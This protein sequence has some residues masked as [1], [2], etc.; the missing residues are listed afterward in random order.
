M[1][2]DPIEIFKSYP[3]PPLVV[4]DE[5]V[6]NAKFTLPG[7]GLKIRLCKI[8]YDGQEPPQA[9]SGWVKYWNEGG[10]DHLIDSMV[11]WNQHQGDTHTTLCPRPGWIP[12]GSEDECHH[13]RGYATDTYG[14]LVKY[15]NPQ[16]AKMDDFTDVI[17]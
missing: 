5:T 1:A 7:T 16:K 3:Q 15:Y 11:I 9:A 14:V 13:L 6:C 10:K 4:F 17:T 2:T 8:K 12:P